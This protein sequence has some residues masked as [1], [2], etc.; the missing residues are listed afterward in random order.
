MGLFDSITSLF[1]S[2]VSGSDLFSAG[3]DVLGSTDVGGL[4]LPGSAVPVVYNP[5]YGS[6][7]G[8]GGPMAIPTSGA[9]GSFAVSRALTS[10]PALALT[11]QKFRM[12]R[13]PMTIEKLWALL[14]RFG[15]TALTAT[16]AGVITAQTIAD[17]MYYKTTHKKRRMNVANTRALRRSVR[18]LKGFERLSHR[19]SAQLGRLSRSGRSRGRSRC[20]TC[21]SS[22]CKC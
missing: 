18:R 14:K 21:R 22:P 16:S 6:M 11:L 2:S 7:G 1:D 9:S 3:L 8:Y 5:T 19:V 12:Q 4:S 15:P 10:F 20:A 17:L 13:I